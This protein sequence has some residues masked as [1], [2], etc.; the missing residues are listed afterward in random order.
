MCNKNNFFLIDHSK[1][2]EASHLNSSGLHLN[3]NG[4]NIPSSISQRFSID[5]YQ[6]TL[7]VVIFLNQISRKMSLET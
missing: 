6:V 1:K 4:A 7:H 5:N 2:I 3:S